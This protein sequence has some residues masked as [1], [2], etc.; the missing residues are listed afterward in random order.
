VWRKKQFVGVLWFILL[1][2]RIKIETFGIRPLVLIV[3]PDNQRNVAGAH[4]GWFLP[5]FIKGGAE[6][7]SGTGPPR[8]S[9]LPPFFKGG[10]FCNT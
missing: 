4:L 9:P 2:R 7:I 10:I 6:G 5:P 1:I 8:K 3:P